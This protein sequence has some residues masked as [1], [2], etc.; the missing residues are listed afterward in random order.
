MRAALLGAFVAV[1]CAAG[2]ATAAPILSQHA[3]WYA[4]IEHLN[5]IAKTNNAKLGLAPIR[6]VSATC[7][8]R[9]S[10]LRWACDGLLY[11]RNA[12]CAVMSNPA[13]VVLDPSIGFVSVDWRSPV[14]VRH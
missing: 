8:R 10:R 4:M 5:L 14:C 9:L 1:V 11:Y 3:A 12:T 7:T 13:T 2:V 6:N